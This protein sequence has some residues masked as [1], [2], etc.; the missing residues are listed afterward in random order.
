MPMNNLYIDEIYF[1]ER[2]LL[3]SSDTYLEKFKKNNPHI[4]Y[5]SGFD[6]LL[7]IT[8]GSSSK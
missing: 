8:N 7:Q 2:H 6:W 1:N 5:K 4:N 3:K